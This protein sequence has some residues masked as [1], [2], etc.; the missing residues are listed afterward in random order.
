MEA[1]QIP[2]ARRFATVVP[3]AVVVEAPVLENAE[4][5]PWPGEAESLELISNLSNDAVQNLSGTLSIHTRTL[6]PE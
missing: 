5:E 3:E 4:N 6:V 1:Q 2:Q